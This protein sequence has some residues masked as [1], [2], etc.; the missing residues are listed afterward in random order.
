MCDD[1]D[2]EKRYEFSE[3]MTKLFVGAR[4]TINNTIYDFKNGEMNE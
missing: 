4:K 3:N 1:E 2:L